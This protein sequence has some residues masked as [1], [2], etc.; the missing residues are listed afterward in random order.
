MARERL[1]VNPESWYQ[2]LIEIAALP[3]KRRFEVLANLHEETTLRYIESLETMSDS[4]AG[5]ISSDGRTIKDLVAHIMTWEVWVIQVMEDSNINKRLNNFMY[6]EDF[7]LGSTRFSFLDDDDFNRFVSQNSS[8]LSWEEI[9]N[10]AIG[11]A[12]QVCYF[13]HPVTDEYMSQVD[14]REDLIWTLDNT[15][16][17]TWKAPYSNAGIETTAGWYIWMMAIE[18]EA[19]EHAQDLYPKFRQT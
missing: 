18:H 16:P 8:N 17:Y 7:E 13:F 12:R 4:R 11:A 19:I 9:K 2:N 5:S 6:L 10:A 1:Q 3:A 15:S 14:Y